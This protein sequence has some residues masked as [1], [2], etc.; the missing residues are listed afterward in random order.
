M[1][2]TRE[3]IFVSTIRSLCTAFGAILGVVI[4]I[5]LAIVALLSING[6]SLLPPMS[7]PK[8]SPDAEG[9]RHMLPLSSPA[10]LRI[11]LHGIIGAGKL[12]ATDIENILLDSREGILAHDR[13]KG[14]FLHIDTP[15]GIAYDSDIIY[16]LILEYKNKF[17]V[18]VYAFVDGLC[19][20]GGML[21]SCAC[22]KIFA[23]SS[24]VIGS[25]GVILGPNF[26]FSKLMDI[27]GIQSLTLSEGKDKDMLN[28]YRPWQPGEDESLRV[29][30]ASQYDQFVDTVIKARPQM[31]KSQ[32]VNVYGAQVYLAPKAQEL[33]YIDDGNSQY[34]DALSALAS[35]AGIE[36]D[37]PYQVIELSTPHSLF[38][39]LSSFSSSLFKG[40]I[41]HTF[42]L[43]PLL[44]PEINGKLLYLYIPR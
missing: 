25:V 4:A 43:S 7:E 17:K 3:S 33:G 12:T 31:D 39:E 42:E 32:L 40:K 24:S 26:N 19:A 16:Q 9:N 2:F 34:N 23:T 21:V 5:A 22:D 10:I 8:I 35:A 27:V 38:D 6:P 1:Q 11:N 44:P 28:P 13:L 18:P 41:T 20:S 37:E 29:I 36:K 15:G 14:V 30:I